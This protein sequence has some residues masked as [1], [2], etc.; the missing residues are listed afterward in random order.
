MYTFKL[1]DGGEMY[2]NQSDPE[3]SFQKAMNKKIENN[4]LLKLKKYMKFTCPFTDTVN[5]S[6]KEITV[7]KIVR[8]KGPLKI[9][10][11]MRVRCSLTS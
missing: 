1:K 10:E 2:F 4:P 3:L 6:E 9:H 7:K 5:S 8:K 11:E